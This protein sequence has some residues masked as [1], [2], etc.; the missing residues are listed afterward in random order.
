[1]TRVQSSFIQIILT[2]ELENLVME[3]ESIAGKCRNSFGDFGCIG[4]IVGA[5]VLRGNGTRLV[6]LTEGG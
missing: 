3:I 6:L 2:N 1:M 4:V 5:R